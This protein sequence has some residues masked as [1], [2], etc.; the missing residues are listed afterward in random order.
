M[1]ALAAVEQTGVREWA[2][3][4]GYERHLGSSIKVKSAIAWSDKRARAAL[5]GGIVADADQPA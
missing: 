2:E 5:L 3:A 4:R 1:R